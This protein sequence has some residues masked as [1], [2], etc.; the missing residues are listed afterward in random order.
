MRDWRDCAVS[1]RLGEPNGMG[2]YALIRDK[3]RAMAKSWD[4]GF[5]EVLSSPRV[6]CFP[7]TKAGRPFALRRSR[8]RAA[9]ARLA[10]PSRPRRIS[11]RMTREATGPWQAKW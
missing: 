5:Y 1:V 11:W 9:I 3:M 4:K 2:L 6:R 10:R 8:E 7:P